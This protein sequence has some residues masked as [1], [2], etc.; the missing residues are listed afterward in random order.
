MSENKGCRI[1]L[2]METEFT[3]VETKY[4]LTSGN[5]FKVNGIERENSQNSR[6]ARD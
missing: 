5:I 3:K 4:V 1:D 6:T 2:N